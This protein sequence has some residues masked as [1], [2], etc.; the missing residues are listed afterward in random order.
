MMHNLKTTL[1]YDG[2][3]A[4][5]SLSVSF[6]NA[7]EAI[8][9]TGRLAALCRGSSNPPSVMTRGQRTLPPLKGDPDGRFA[10][11]REL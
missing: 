9:F 6:A 7:V 4:T 1:A 8:Q 5:V 10:N 2:D 3:G 11:G